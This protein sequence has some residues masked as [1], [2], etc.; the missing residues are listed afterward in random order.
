M[1]SASFPVAPIPNPLA[2]EK[3]LRDEFAMYALAGMISTA[4]S[5][6]LQ[7]QNGHEPLTAEKAY[8]MADAML[9]A[10]QR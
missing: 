2:S 3:T 9:Y 5:P 6:C 10:R 8:L 1:T 4:A 7:G